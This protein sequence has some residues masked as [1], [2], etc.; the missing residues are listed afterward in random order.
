MQAVRSLCAHAI[1][2]ISL[3]CISPSTQCGF[4]HD[5]ISQATGAD[6]TVRHFWERGNGVQYVAP[7]NGTK[8]LSC[9]SPY[10]LENLVMTKLLVCSTIAQTSFARSGDISQRLA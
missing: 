5:Q 2:A 6:V 4:G 7:Q 8:C 1:P 3:S 9:T 10:R